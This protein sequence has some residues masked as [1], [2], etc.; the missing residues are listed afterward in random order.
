MAYIR[1]CGCCFRRV[2]IFITRSTQ[3]LTTAKHFNWKKP[4]FEVDITDCEDGVEIKIKSNVFAKNVRIDFDEYDCVLSDNFFDITNREYYVISSK[5]NHKAQ[6]LKKSLK[7]I[8][9]YDIG[10]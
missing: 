2:G 6:E 5:T 4:E 9:V 1:Y 3:I 7:I 8:S 10:R